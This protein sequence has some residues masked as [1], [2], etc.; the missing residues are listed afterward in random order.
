MTDSNSNTLPAKDSQF[1]MRT[2]TNQ[3]SDVGEMSGSPLQAPE[4]IEILSTHDERLKIIGKELADD[5]GRA[6]FTI[7]CQKRIIS[8]ADIAKILS[9]SLPLVNWHV[10]RML[11]S[12]LIK[13]EKLAMSQ[14]NKPV[15]YYAP[16]STIIVIGTEFGERGK[17]DAGSSDSDGDN[18]DSLTRRRLATSAIWSRL[19]RSI[20]AALVAFVSATSVIYVIGR[21]LAGP[22]S[23]NGKL[24]S[25]NGI[26]LADPDAIA[27]M[28]PASPIDS[29][30][31]FLYAVIP[32]S[33]ADI[34][35][36]L[37][38]GALIGAI[39]LMVMKTSKPRPRG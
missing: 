36:A 31:S 19:T 11:N 7:I 14:K 16:A 23:E 34:L 12:G 21:T 33:L 22:E 3:D 32:P 20:S 5:T 24:A 15:K 8:A 13:I 28:P 9:I 17:D 38:G 39:V 6:I 10:H 29:L 1:I 25:N 4:G 35:M 26:K 18:N 27:S 37:L 2:R 30:P